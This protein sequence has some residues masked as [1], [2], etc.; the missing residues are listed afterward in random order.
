MT[1]VNVPH[2]DKTRI[3]IACVADGQTTA[4]FEESIDVPWGQ[5]QL[6]GPCTVAVT[7]HGPEVVRICEPSATGDG[8]STCWIAPAGAFGHGLSPSL[9][10][11][12]AASPG[13]VVVG[14]FSFVLPSGRV[15]P[16]SFRA[17]NLWRSLDALER[18]HADVAD[19]SL[20]AM[21][22]YERRRREIELVCKAQAEIHGFPQGRVFSYVPD[23]PD[24]LIVPSTESDQPDG[25][26]VGVEVSELID[27]AQHQSYS[28]AKEVVS[29]AVRRW[30]DE[31]GNSE[32]P[33]RLNYGITTE[34][35][36]CLKSGSWRKSNILVEDA[37]HIIECSINEFRQPSSPMV[38]SRLRRKRTLDSRLIPYVWRSRQRRR[39]VREAIHVHV[40]VSDSHGFESQYTNPASGTTYR[41]GRLFNDFGDDVTLDAERLCKLVKR[42]ANKLQRRFPGSMPF[43]SLVLYLTG[44]YFPSGHDKTGSLG[45]LHVS[46]VHPD[47]SVRHQIE[48]F[49]HVYIRCESSYY[50][51]NGGSGRFV[52]LQ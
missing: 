21:R 5:V 6:Q 30:V 43:Y 18:Q 39:E 4:T 47:R 28:R 25:H 14:R 44:E 51:I 9:A 35:I 12:E 22:D 36:G 10:A 34:L 20:S 38:E 45:I 40:S 1:L 29:L 46:D 26:G 8:H 33:V 2:M 48:P 3:A 17:D 15:Y 41:N 52:D 31:G 27:E 24:V 37:L 49:S 11:L 19:M 32:R 50:V 16:V 42:K 7:N 23:P 13:C